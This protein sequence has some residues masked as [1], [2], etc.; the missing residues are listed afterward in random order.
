MAVARKEGLAMSWAFWSM[1]ED[2]ER[3]VVLTDP[4]RLGGM[5]V[6]QNE[7]AVAGATVFIAAGNTGEQDGERQSITGP[8]SRRLLRTTTDEAGRF[9]IDGLPADATFEVGAEKRGYGTVTSFNLQDRSSALQY[10]AGDEDVTLVMPIEARIEGRV[11][12]EGSDKPVAGIA[13]VAKGANIIS[14]F[15]GAPV[16]SQE[17]GTFAVDSLSPDTYTVGP[18][19]PE[20]RLADWVAAPVKLTLGAGQVSKD[21]T[22]KVSKGILFEMHVAETGTGKPIEGAS[23]HIRSEQAQQWLSGRTNEDG[24]ARIRVMPGRY[25]ISGVYKQGYASD[26]RQETVTIDENVN[27]RMERKLKEAPKVRGMVYDPAGK[28]LEG[29]DV[30]IMPG[31]GEDVVSDS[32]GGFEIVWN[33]GY[34]GIE[35]TTFCIVARHEQRNLALAMEI[36]VGKKELDLKLEPG[37]VLCGKVVDPDGKAIAAARVNT[38][39]N[40]SNWGSSLARRKQITTDDDGAFEIKAVPGHHKYDITANADGYG[41]TRTNVHADNAVE[42]RLDVGELTLLVAN[43]SVSG[44]IVD[45]QGNPVGGAQIESSGWGDGQ[46]DRCTATADGEGIFTLDGVCE[47]KINLRV[48][49]NQDGKRLSARVVTNGGASDTKIVVCEGRAVVQYLGGKTYEQILKTAEKLVA[50]VVVDKNGSP[51]AGVP[52]GVCCIKKQREPGKFVWS[53]SSYNELRATTDKQGRFAIEL[54]EGT[55]YNL[56]FS[57]DNHAAL[58]VYDIPAGK[59]DLKVTLPEGG[60]L[61][62]RLVRLDKGQ[63]A[64]IPNAEVKIEQV[65]RASHTHLGFDRDRTTVTDSQGR[66][67]FE[68]VRTKIRPDRGLSKKQWKHVPRVWQISYGDTS[69]TIAFD[70]SGLI[71]DFEL[72]VKPDLSQ[73]TLTAGSP[74]PEFDGIKIDLPTDQTKDKAILV[75]FFD[76][77]QRPSRHCVTQLAKQAEALKAKGVTIITIQASK[78]DKAKLDQWAQKSNITSPLGIIEGD[79]ELI[80]ATWG[81]KS[82]PW[83]ILADS[84]QKV[85]AEGFTLSELDEHIK[86]IGKGD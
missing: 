11:L 20:G 73:A 43:L 66:F 46:P 21:V 74:L 81:A 22:V 58:I 57:P 17:D 69:Q 49:A 71:D 29:A 9:T 60:T 19:V 51:V 75:C 1:R 78:A 55:E 18:A 13:M 72:I 40:V 36:A 14:Y 26:A 28:P 30:R 62:G 59:K 2:V 61:N 80:R 77:Q 24:V 42:G 50:G 79:T 86:A 53:Y 45:K 48:E 82:L 31:G 4:K 23:V 3:E 12:E 63:K 76:Y 5:V 15:Q 54:D 37:V 47:G 84:K 25:L 52:V 7:K 41:S 16:L 85:V 35:G 83:L 27:Q 32:Q 33:P 10:S 34:W 67:R 38:M 70:D 6:D 64:S 8:L 44:K 39:L 68:H 56:R 65:D